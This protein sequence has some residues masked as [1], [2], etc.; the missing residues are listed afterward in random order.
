MLSR[1]YV[2]IPPDPRR[3]LSDQIVSSS[4]LAADRGDRDAAMADM[5]GAGAGPSADGAF[6]EYGGI[7]P[8]MDPEL[9][10]VRMPSLGHSDYSYIDGL[11]IG[12]AYVNGG[13]TRTSA[14]IATATS[15]RRR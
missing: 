8:N 2:A 7:D 14:C 15:C 6:E 4:V 12:H 1:H 5:T 11:C 3:L 9:A 10:M 13:R